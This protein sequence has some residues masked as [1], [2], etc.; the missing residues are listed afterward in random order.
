VWK[1]IAEKIRHLIEIQ[2]P[3]SQMLAGSRRTNGA[4]YQVEQFEKI[5]IYSDAATVI[6]N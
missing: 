5:K 2:I 4:E 3:S 6:E 1:T